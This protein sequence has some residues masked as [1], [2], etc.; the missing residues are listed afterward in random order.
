M[1]DGRSDTADFALNPRPTIA[2]HHVGEEREPVLVVDNATRSPQALVDF[3]ATETPFEPVVPGVNG[4]PGIRAPA[5]RKYVADL[6]AALSPLIERAFGLQGVEQGRVQCA[7]SMVTLPPEDLIVAQRLP[8]VDTVDPLQFA[9]LHFLCG[10]EF[11]GTAFYRHRSTGF[12]TL[13]PER[14]AVYQ[15][16]LAREVARQPPPA[17]YVV[18]DTPL[19]TQTAAFDARMDRVLVYRS[20]VLH[21]GQVRPDDPL[22]ADPRKGRLTANVFLNYRPA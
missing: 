9:V 10:E 11:G 21:S 12:E 14:A 18:G 20:R 2:L 22:S 6:V 7:F 4:Y 15:A 5:P 1:A 13:S 17:A 19:H 16:E 3:A 8:H